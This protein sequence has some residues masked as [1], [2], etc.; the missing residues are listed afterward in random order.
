VNK[1]YW[2]QRT[3]RLNAAYRI[4]E[5]AGREEYEQVKLELRLA[6]REISNEEYATEKYGD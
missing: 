2:H 3:T 6:E 4:S 5:Q 1:E